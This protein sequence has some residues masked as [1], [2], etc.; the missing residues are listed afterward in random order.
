MADKESSPERDVHHVRT[1]PRATPIRPSGRI[2]MTSGPIRAIRRPRPT[3]WT[4]ATTHTP[5]GA[6]S[7][8]EPHHE[9]D[10]EVDPAQGQPART[11]P[12][13]SPPRRALSAIGRILRA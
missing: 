2:R 13:P 4:S 5:T 8:S 11:V 12:A 6:T 9:V 10:P 7:T 3:R 1:S